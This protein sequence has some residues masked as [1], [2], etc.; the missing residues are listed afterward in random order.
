M[1]CGNALFFQHIPGIFDSSCSLGEKKEK[2]SSGLTKPPW[3]L[4]L[5]SF[6]K[7]SGMKSPRMHKGSLRQNQR[8]WFW[9]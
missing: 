9:R 1:V 6:F 4:R 5:R 8:R 7:I 3:S 2:G